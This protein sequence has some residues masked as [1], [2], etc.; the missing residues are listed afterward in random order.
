MVISA[1]QNNEQNNAIN[2]IQY[3]NFT[4]SNQ[5]YY[6]VRKITSTPWLV[7][8][9]GKALVQIE[10]NLI[11]LQLII[12]QIIFFTI[13]TNAITIINDIIIFMNMLLYYFLTIINIFA[14]QNHGQSIATNR[15]QSNNSSRCNHLNN[16]VMHIT[17]ATFAGQNNDKTLLQIVFNLITLQMILI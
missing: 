15:I 4:E 7:N 16:L 6:F 1:S 12:I 10:F 2:S 8:I 17:I 11:I 5:S 9:M 13:I 14:S 3:Y